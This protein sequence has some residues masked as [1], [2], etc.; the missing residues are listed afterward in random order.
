MSDDEISCTNDGGASVL[1]NT[2]L[3]Y[4]KRKLNINDISYFN[5]TIYVTG[6]TK[7]ILIGTF[8]ILRNTVLKYI[9]ATVVLLCHTVA[10]PDLLY[11]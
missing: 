5:N 8:C 9:E 7:N 6:F 4:N 10:T 11:K 1:S 3:L 2:E